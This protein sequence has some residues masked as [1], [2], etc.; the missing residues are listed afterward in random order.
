MTR[1]V[2]GIH[3]ECQT[4][5]FTLSRD[6]SLSRGN[7]I[8]PSIKLRFD[9]LNTV[10]VIDDRHLDT[11]LMKLPMIALKNCLCAVGVEDTCASNYRNS[12]TV[13]VAIYSPVKRWKSIEIS[14]PIDLFTL[15]GYSAPKGTRSSK[16]A[17]QVG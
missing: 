5:N 12:F 7:E 11:S 6:A 13:I 2:A 8:F 4:T 9:T 10:L 15:H 1:H 3:R 14:V 17:V 16:H